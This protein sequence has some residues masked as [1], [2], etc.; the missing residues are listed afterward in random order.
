MTHGGCGDFG[1]SFN[2]EE[3]RKREDQ[4]NRVLLILIYW[5]L[6]KL[7]V[8]SDLAQLGEY[9]LTAAWA[10]IISQ[11]NEVALSYGL[12]PLDPSELEGILERALTDYRAELGDLDTDPEAVQL[13][14]E[15]T[16]WYI[17]WKTHND[18]VLS[19][20]QKAGHTHI[21]WITAMDERVCPVCV[22]NEGVHRI[23]SAPELPPHPE[24]RC[25]WEFIETL[26]GRTALS[27]VHTD[28]MKKIS[29][30]RAIRG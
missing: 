16:S 12:E 11:V 24:C 23:D 22:A 25:H 19:V 21:R 1:L 14:V 6:Q 5:Y 2:E 15:Q 30:R 7:M 10:D 29:R 18:A 8:L 27:R 3:T 17:V 26:D 9:L 28:Y 4:L 13:R 20:A